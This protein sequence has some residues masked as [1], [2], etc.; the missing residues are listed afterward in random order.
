MPKRPADTPL[1][2]LYSRTLQVCVTREQ[3]EA[4]EAMAKA[5]GKSR[6]ELIR[7]ILERALNL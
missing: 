6:S 3:L 5:A 1:K 4:I 7:E 2:Q